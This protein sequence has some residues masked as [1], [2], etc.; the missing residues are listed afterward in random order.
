MH[1]N[2]PKF[3]HLKPAKAPLS[4]VVQ[5]RQRT[6][7]HQQSKEPENQAIGLAEN[8]SMGFEIGFPNCY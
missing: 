1:K 2:D 6:K 3:L 5:H 8:L 4:P 7:D